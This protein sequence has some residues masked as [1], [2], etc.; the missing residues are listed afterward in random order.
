MV[1]AEQPVVSLSPAVARLRGRYRSFRQDIDQA[2]ALGHAEA[3]ASGC[4]LEA[5]VGSAVRQTVADLKP[6]MRIVPGVRLEGLAVD[7]RRATGSPW[8]IPSHP[9]ADDWR[10]FNRNALVWYWHKR[11]LSQRDLASMFHLARSAVQDVLREFAAYES[12][13]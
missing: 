13:L 9:K 5:A 3:Q 11:G 2:V 7:H 1:R 6:W 4:D 10:R 8:V 12:H